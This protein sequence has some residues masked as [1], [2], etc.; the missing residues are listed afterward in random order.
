MARYPL[1]FGHALTAADLA[2]FGAVEVALVGDAGSKDLEA[3]VRAANAPFVPSLVLAGGPQDDGSD[4]ALLA[5]RRMRG[6]RATAYVCRG[7]V[8]DEPVTDPS[9]LFDQLARASRATSA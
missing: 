1:A 9:A 8:C 5:E 3:L 2:V 6:G 7:A 4:I